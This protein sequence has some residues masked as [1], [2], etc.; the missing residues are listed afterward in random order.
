LVC[1]M[2]Q[3]TEFVNIL[4]HVTFYTTLYVLYTLDVPRPCP[5]DPGPSM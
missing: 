4:L 3:L 5:P 1:C 2:I